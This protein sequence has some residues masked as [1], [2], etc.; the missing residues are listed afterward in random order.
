MNHEHADRARRFMLVVRRACLMI[1]A[2]VEAETGTRGNAE[3][4]AR[5]W[6]DDDTPLQFRE[7]TDSEIERLAEALRARSLTR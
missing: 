5:L 4:T 1:A 6:P 2:W 3:A 7:L